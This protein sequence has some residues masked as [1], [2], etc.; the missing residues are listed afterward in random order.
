M[1]G[2]WDRGFR[3]IFAVETVRDI[4]SINKTIL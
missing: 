4:L 3:F 1:F 2:A